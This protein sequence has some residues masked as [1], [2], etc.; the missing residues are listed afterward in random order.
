MSLI[1]TTINVTDG[2]ETFR[3]N[4]N[5]NFAAVKTELDLVETIVDVSNTAVTAL[6]ATIEV[7]QRATSTEILK[8]EA[9]ANIVGNLTVAGTSSLG[10]TNVTSGN[11]LSVNSANLNVLGTT[12]KLILEGELQLESTIVEKD[13][14]DSDLDASLQG[15]YTSVASDVGTLAVANKHAMILDFSAYSS[16]VAVENL[17]DVTDINLE[18]GTYQGQQLTLIVNAFASAGKPH[19]FT[20]TNINSLAGGEFIS[21]NVDNAV[22]ELVYVGTGWTVKN[23]FNATIV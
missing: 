22:I 11:S 4:I 2:V 6:N 23:L 15:N 1:I 13:F 18:Q 10:V 5:T 9:S 12:S 14:G 21:V 8:V 7:G 3:P 16:D 20:D 19:R 17:N